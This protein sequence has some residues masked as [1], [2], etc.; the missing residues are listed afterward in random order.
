MREFRI[1][2]P[3]GTAPSPAT[4]VAGAEPHFLDEDL[5]AADATIVGYYPVTDAESAAPLLK[6]AE[7]LGFAARYLN[8]TP[9]DGTAYAWVIVSVPAISNG[10]VTHRQSDDTIGQRIAALRAQRS[11]SIRQLAQ[12]ARVSP[13]TLS[14]LERGMTKTS[15]HTILRIADAFGIDVGCIIDDYQNAQ[16]ATAA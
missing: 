12:A 8:D 3:F 16:E 6:A 9:H 2:V 5:A 1:M 13:A 15:I 14:R 4:P 10:G 11:M 7:L